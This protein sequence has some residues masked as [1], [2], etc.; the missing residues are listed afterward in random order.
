MDQKVPQKHREK[1]EKGKWVNNLLPE[2]IA[3]LP[4]GNFQN[5]VI[6]IIPRRFV[7]AIMNELFDSQVGQFRFEPFKGF[8]LVAVVILFLQEVEKIQFGFLLFVEVCDEVSS[9][10]SLLFLVYVNVTGLL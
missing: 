5:I 3:E 7:P 6:V 4:D 9:R 10:V 1:L 8:G 2:D